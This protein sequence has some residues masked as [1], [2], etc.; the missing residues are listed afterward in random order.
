MQVKNYIKFSYII[1]F[2][3]NIKRLGESLNLSKANHFFKL[4]FNQKYKL[5]ESYGKIGLEKDNLK[6]I[7][8][9]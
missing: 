2:E 6:N 4:N 3:F 5:K 7:I 9:F 8:K 1:Y